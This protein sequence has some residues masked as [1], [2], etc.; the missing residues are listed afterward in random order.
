MFWH[1][2]NLGHF[3][4]VYK[5]ICFILRHFGVRNG[6]ECWIAGGIGGFWAFG[7]SEGI[8][9]A[10]NNQI[11][12]YLFSR[13]IEGMMQSFAERGYLPQQLNPRTKLGFRFFAGFSLAL[14]LYMTDYEENFLKKG[15]MSTMNYLYYES[16]SGPWMP[17]R[18]YAPVVFVVLLSTF[19]VFFPRLELDRMLTIVDRPFSAPPASRSAVPKTAKSVAAASASI[20]SALIVTPSDQ[21]SS[22]SSTPAPSFSSS[23]S[24]SSSVLPPPLAV[25]TPDVVTTTTTISTSTTTAIIE[26]ESAAAVETV[27]VTAEEIEVVSTA[28]SSTTTETSV[29]KKQKK[30]K[31]RDS[32]S[33]SDSDSSDSSDSDEE[34]SRKKKR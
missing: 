24:S 27:V 28:A 30:K 16:N 15:F 6:F 9:G 23:F 13:G 11:V 3:V 33:H 19:A 29:S 5:C 32:D 7:E 12:L 20:A 22:S 25:S 21:S 34:K 26:V 4:L 17:P 10:V 14:I 31:N 18:N 1:G 2:R 8:S